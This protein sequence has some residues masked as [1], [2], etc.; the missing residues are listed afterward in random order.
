MKKEKVGSEKKE[1]P[2]PEKFWSILVNV[3]FEFYK[4]HFR[5]NDG[6][7]LS[8]NWNDG[9]RGMESKGLKGVIQRLR[10]ICEEKGIDW[11]EEKA[12]SELNMFF[13]KAFSKPFFQKNFMCCFLNKYKD[14][15]IVSEYQTPLI[16]KI[17]NSWYQIFPDK[18]DLE[19]DVKGSEII[20]GYLKQQYIQNNLIFNDESAM[21]SVN[22]IFLHIKADEFWSKKSLVSIGYNISE[23]VLK[24]KSKQNG[25]KKTFTRAG[26]NEE[27]NR[28]NYGEQQSR[29]NEGIKNGDKP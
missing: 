24:I 22:T 16:K 6:F 3:Y 29:Y 27:F 23:F 12:V 17:L 10:T 2:P 20:I 25:N 15:I 21:S 18:K 1:V 11:T 4:R 19:R 7:A 13:E 28:R 14:V 5:D 9:R 8:P 26:V